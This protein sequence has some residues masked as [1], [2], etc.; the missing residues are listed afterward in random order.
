[1]K[2]NQKK[3]T[4]TLFH[5]QGSAE[6]QVFEPEGERRFD[7][8]LNWSLEGPQRM[9]SLLRSR[10]E[11]LLSRENRPTIE[12]DYFFSFWLISWQGS[13]TFVLS[14]MK[15]FIYIIVIIFY[16]HD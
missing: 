10:S 2:N 14:N 12:T 7:R 11:R 13:F 9:N 1:M 15:P 16:A 6:W 4:G 3:L 8:S 5:H